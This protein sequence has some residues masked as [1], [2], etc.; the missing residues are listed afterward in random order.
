VQT[1]VIDTCQVAGLA[2]EGSMP[3]GTAQPAIDDPRTREAL[4]RYRLR[5]LRAAL[6]GLGG[7]VVATIVI[8]SAPDGDPKGI[9]YVVALF[10]MS[11]GGLAFFLGVA[12]LLRSLRMG[13]LF[14]RT[15]WT[16][17]RAAYRIAPI[18]ANGQPAL[19]IM[20]DGS[21]GESVCSVSA[22]AGRYQQL[23]EGPDIPLLVAGNPRRWS[24]IAPP[25]L[26]VLL[27]AKRPRMP[28]WRRKLR[29]YAIP[30]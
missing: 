7:L 5:C 9:A 17:R 11:W 10:G 19:V 3:S 25:D 14:K 21:G 15:A 28:F 29:D 24:V 18:G 2:S 1:T 12:T 26:H 6:L 20:E 4:R 22:T 8:G 13:A 23:E 16:E 27:V 30:E